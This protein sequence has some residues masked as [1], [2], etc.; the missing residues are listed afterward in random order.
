MIEK[1]QFLCITKNGAVRGKRWTRQTLSDAWD[2][3]NSDG[4]CDTPWQMVAFGLKL[5]KKVTAHKEGAGPP[6][7][8][9]VVERFPEAEPRRFY[10]LSGDID[11][12]GPTPG[13][14][15]GIACKAH[16]NECR[17]RI[18]MTGKARMNAH[19]DRV[20]KETVRGWLVGYRSM[21]SL[22]DGGRYRETQTLPPPRM[23]RSQTGD[24][25]GLQKVGAK[26]K[27]LKEEVEVAKRYC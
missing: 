2:A 27:N 26:S 23:V 19:R 18:R 3:T 22:P 16:S 7:P 11:A 5:T 24:P 25:R 14:G 21:S 12:R 8:R 9:I 4:L 1:E 20:A 17:E 10:V 13:C 6:L 15:Y